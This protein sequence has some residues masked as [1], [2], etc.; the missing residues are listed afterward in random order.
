[1]SRLSQEDDLQQILLGYLTDILIIAET[2]LDAS[3]SATYSTQNAIRWR[4]GTAMPMA[5]V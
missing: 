5:V 4:G 1:M 3:F 2:K